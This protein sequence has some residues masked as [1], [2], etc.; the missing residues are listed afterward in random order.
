MFLWNRSVWGSLPPP[1]LLPGISLEQTP[2]GQP[3]FSTLSPGISLEQTPAGT[4]QPFPHYSPGVSLERALAEI[5]CPLP[6][7]PREFLGN[8]HWLR[9]SV[10]PHTA[11]GVVFPGLMKLPS[12]ALWQSRWGGSQKLGSLPM[13]MPDRLRAGFPQDIPRADLLCGHKKALP[14]GKGFFC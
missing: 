6:H 9:E 12:Y 4:V 14:D 10:L 2:P 11:D 8:G 7:Y 13:A 1:A 5:A 3:D